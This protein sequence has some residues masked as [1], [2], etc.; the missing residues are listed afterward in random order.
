MNKYNAYAKELNCLYVEF[1]EYF[2]WHNDSKEWEPRKK[3]EAIGRIFSYRPSD[4]EKFFLKLLLL[5]VRKPTSF[6][7]LRTIN[8]RT[9][10]T[11]REAAQMLGLMENDHSADVCLEEATAYLMPSALR[12]LFATVLIYCNPA[13]PKQLW[14]KFESFLSQ[15]FEHK[16]YFD[17]STVRHKVLGILSYYLPSMGKRLEDFFSTNDDVTLGFSNSLDKELRTEQEIITPEEDVLSVAQLND[18]QKIAYNRIMYH[19]NN[20]LP[21]VFFVDGPGGGR[22]SH[23]RFKIPL[24]ENDPKPCNINKQSTLA[25]LIKLA[26]LIIWD[27]ATMAKRSIIEKFDEMLRDIMDSASIFGGKI[28]VFGG[29]FRQ[30]LPIIPK[31]NKADVIDASIVMSPLWNQFDKLNLK[32]N[33]RALLDPDFSSY[34][35]R[36]GNGLEETNGKDE[37]QI[38]PTANIL[39]TDDFTSLNE[40]I[41]IVF[42]NIE[43]CNLD[44]SLFVKRA[45][46]TT[47]NEFV[48]EVN[49]VLINKFH[50]EETTYFSCDD[51]T[52]N[53]VVPNQEELFHSLTPQGL[54]P[55]KLTLKINAP[56]ILLRNI[57]PTEGLCNGTR[58]L[59]KGF[60]T[61]VIYAEISVGMHAG[62]LVFVP[63]ITLEA[64][65]DDFSTIPFKRKQFPVRLCYAMTINKAQ[66]QTL[67]FVGVYLKEPVFHTASFMLRYP[68]QKI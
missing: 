15:D 26:K 59:C 29:D 33:M 16:Q 42:P 46:L 56:I 53:C 23:S 39:F 25:H 63:R 18:E 68:E 40:L 11:F 49:D 60:N 1:P 28:I 8:G 48:H 54:P 22:T 50:G 20:N 34:L 10:P 19:V 37:I 51:N 4:G 55:H 66:G 13:N 52:N 14:S 67:D 65:C 47:R 36:I 31:G 3:H 27:E 9:F 6:T 38:P 12:Q 44:F 64:P 17:P 43:D 24:D 21:N 58:L 32:Q 5:H 2:T 62:K 57:N 41:E 35:M 45:I 7:N 61:N 30:T